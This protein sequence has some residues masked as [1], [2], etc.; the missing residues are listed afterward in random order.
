MAERT[1]HLDPSELLGFRIVA[2]R[3]DTS[4]DARLG[5]K[6]GE[7]KEDAPGS[8]LGAKVG[9]KLGVGDGKGGAN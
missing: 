5:G 1:V 7:V 2:D 6:I 4:D 3:D 8:R 9:G